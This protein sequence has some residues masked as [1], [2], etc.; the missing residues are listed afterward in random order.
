MTA[1]ALALPNVIGYSFDVAPDL[2]RSE[3]RRKLSPGALRTFVNIVDK[4]NL[5]EAQ[6]R[7][8]LG[9]VASS[10]FHAWKTNPKGR[11]LDQDTLTRISLAIGIYKALNIYFNK[12]LADRW[13]L[14]GNRSAMFAGNSPLDYMV[15]NG[16]PGMVDVRRML[17][18]WRGGI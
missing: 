16:L 5:T 13:I 10:T 7:S 12:P 9:G 11:Q 14:L 18:A 4:W 1:T 15:Q 8:L 17:D 6:A 3:V 2:S